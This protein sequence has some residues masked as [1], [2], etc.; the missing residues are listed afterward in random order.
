MKE[1]WEYKKLG[2]VTTKICD[3]SHNPP[4][5]V[6]HSNYLMLSSKNI[7]FDRFDYDSPR[8]LSEGDFIEENKRTNISDGDV[9]LT[10][11]GT[12]GRTCCVTKPFIPFTIQRSVAVLK[13]QK[14]IITSRFLMYSLHSLSNIW[15]S[16]AKGVAQ[17][18]V[19]LKQVSNISIPIPTITE[20]NDI[21]S[22]LDLLSGVIEKQK[23][24]LE[25]LDKLAQSIFYDMFGDPVTNEKGWEIKKLKDIASKIGSGATPRGGNQSYK[26]EGISLIRSMNVHNN[27]FIYDDL[28]FI[29][30]E[31]AAL[32]NNVIVESNDVLLN[33]TGA[34]VARCCMVP[35]DVLPARVNQH[36]CIIRPI[37]DLANSIYLNRFFTSI[38]EQSVLLLLSRSNAATR[39][40]LPKNLLDN[41][42]I[43]LP[44]LTI[45]QEFAA[46]VEAIEAMKAK[47]RQS[48]KEAE[49]LFNE[50]MD[51]YFN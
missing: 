6:E 33:I 28:A 13:P 16:E 7:F 17:K 32:L 50:R 29:D 40:A 42:N 10:I 1:G 15:E 35:D 34:S 37:K 18:G 41:C 51:Y 44:P 2:E 23:A 46:K 27:F 30:D 43:V 21:V 31:Q 11:V 38:E 24:Q 45:Q 36:V 9:L 25:E 4:K 49:T 26:D 14:T 48:L 12:V 22:E 20:Q 5:G 19:Y 39:E 8:Y 47:V 3:G